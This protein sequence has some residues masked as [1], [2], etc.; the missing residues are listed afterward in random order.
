M[1]KNVG[2]QIKT[3]ASIICYSGVALSVI[4]GLVSLFQSDGD[5][6]LAFVGLGIIVV[7]SL[8][9]WLGSIFTYG[10]GELIDTNCKI[11]RGVQISE[12]ETVDFDKKIAELQKLFEADLISEDEYI[13]KRSEIL[14]G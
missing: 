14:N 8:I 11:A 4:I 10:F 1:Y 13:E 7:G 5:G 3:I 2:K 9:S 6:P 12:K